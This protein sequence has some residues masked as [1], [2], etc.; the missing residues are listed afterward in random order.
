MV[1][2]RSGEFCEFRDF[3]FD[4]CHFFFL[5]LLLFQILLFSSVFRDSFCLSF[6][7]FYPL[8]FVRSK[9]TFASS[10]GGGSAAGGIGGFSSLSF[11]EKPAATAAGNPFQTAFG[12]P[13]AKDETAAQ[14]RYAR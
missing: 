7:V 8:F 4:S 3:R 12:Q 2:G 11:G 5:F 10:A 6:S 1:S 9:S 14:G 13:A